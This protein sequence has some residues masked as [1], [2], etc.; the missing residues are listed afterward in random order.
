MVTVVA[1]MDVLVSVT[2]TNRSA[3]TSARWWQSA[4]VAAVSAPSIIASKPGRFVF[5]LIG[6]G[7]RRENYWALAAVVVVGVTVNEVVVG[8]LLSLLLRRRWRELAMARVLSAGFLYYGVL[9][10][11]PGSA[12]LP[13]FSVGLVVKL[14]FGLGAGWLLASIG[15]SDFA[16]MERCCTTR[17]SVLLVDNS[18]QCCGSAPRYRHQ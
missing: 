15:C 12:L 2:L 18:P 5:A 16:G 6:I 9:S 1:R 4:C 14:A 11:V 7:Y 8:F 3:L 10:S 13:E 17:P